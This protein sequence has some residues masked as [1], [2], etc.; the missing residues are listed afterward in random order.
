[1]AFRA[2]P[3]RRVPQFSKVEADAAEV[4][5]VDFAVADFV[6]LERSTVR[7]EGG[8]AQGE[9]AILPDKHHYDRLRFYFG[10]VTLGGTV[11]AATLAVW[12]VGADDQVLLLGTSELSASGVFPPV[13]AENYQ[14]R[15]YVS[16]A[17][18]TGS[19]SPEV[20]VETF[21]QGIH[22]GYVQ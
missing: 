17:L 13:E 14:A 20:S 12:S 7:H 19:A 5:G 6:N 15:Y 11:T 21:I 8:F 2:S 18:L 22:Q 4:F 1:M 16:L 10:P 9:F 3:P